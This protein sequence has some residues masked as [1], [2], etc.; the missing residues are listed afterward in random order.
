[1][2]SIKKTARLTGLVYLGVVISGLFVLM[3]VPGRLF[4]ADNAGATVTNILAHQTLF[5]AYII[6]GLVGELLFITVVL[7]LYRLLKDVNHVQAAVMVLLVL[8]M[9]PLAI[10]GAMNQVATLSLVRGDAL[11]NVFDKPQRDALAT[12]LISNDQTGTLIAEIFWGLWLFPLG[13]LV[14]R[15]G[16]LP[17]F[18]GV[19]LIINGVA[20]LFISMTGLLLPQYVHTVFLMAQPALMGEL[21]LTLWLLIV[22]ARVQRSPASQTEVV[23]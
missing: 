12:L 11:L 10:L 16:F 5:R 3:Y 20:Y 18:L 1:V 22:G 21:A 9:A 23:V 19:W 2:D 6:I 8:L 13:L 4:V 15:S 7:L 14:F 17:R